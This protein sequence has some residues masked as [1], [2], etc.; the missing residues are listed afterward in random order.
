MS[1]KTATNCKCRRYFHYVIENVT[2]RDKVNAIQMSWPNPKLLHSV[3]EQRF[4]AATGSLGT[5]EDVWTRFF[6]PVVEGL[7]TKDYLTSRIIPRP[8]DIIYWCNAALNNASDNRHTIIEQEDI[9]LAEEEYSQYA[10]ESLLSELIARVP[11]A[12]AFLY[13]FI[14]ASKIL[15]YNQV[16]KFAR[17]AKIPEEQIPGVIELLTDTSFLGQEVRPETFAFNLEEGRKRAIQA[18]ARNTAKQVKQVRFLINVPYHAF[19]E[20][21]EADTSISTAKKIPTS[22]KSR[23]QSRRSR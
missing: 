17:T 5:P 21:R 22:T 11:N 7:D 15:T 6:T 16:R 23:T 18:Q 14:R 3:I 2:E 10:T 1:Y 19:L 8:R 4:I 9:L 12:E 13:N 20:I